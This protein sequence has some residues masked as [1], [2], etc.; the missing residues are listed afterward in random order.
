MMILVCGSKMDTIFSAAGTDWI[1]V[2]SENQYPSAFISIRSS[3][4]ISSL[5]STSCAFFA[6]I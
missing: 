4:R 2:L 1:G 3:H 6:A 5:S